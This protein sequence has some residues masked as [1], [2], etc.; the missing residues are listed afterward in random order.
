MFPVNQLTESCKPEDYQLRM[1]L[2]ALNTKT[3]IEIHT[4]AQKFKTAIISDDNET[5]MSGGISTGTHLRSLVNQLPKNPKR[6]FFDIV[7]GE[8]PADLRGIVRNPA[9]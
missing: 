1:E 8:G 3:Q 5:Q 2:L 6:N 9:G 7:I 4:K